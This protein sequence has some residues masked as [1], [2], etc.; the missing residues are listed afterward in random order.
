MNMQ[1][2]NVQ[3]G[4][5]VIE[6]FLGQDVVFIDLNDVI[7]KMSNNVFLFQHLSPSE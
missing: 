3:I 5:V 6:V 2:Y 4:M 7:Q 1:K